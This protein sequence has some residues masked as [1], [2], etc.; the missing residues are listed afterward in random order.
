MNSI[1]SSRF[2]YRRATS[3][4]DVANWLRNA[5]AASALGRRYSSVVTASERLIDVAGSRIQPGI[6][7]SLQAHIK[8]TQKLQ[9]VHIEAT[10][11]V[12]RAEQF[13]LVCEP[14]GRKE[15]GEQITIF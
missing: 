3:P 2:R 13:V 10:I 8:P 15:I 6:G 7:A 9:S 4:F 12:L 14:D 1:P 11:L 5:L